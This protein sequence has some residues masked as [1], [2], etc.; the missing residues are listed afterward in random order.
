MF[1]AVVALSSI[2][3]AGSLDARLVG[4]GLFYS[5]TLA[6]MFTHCVRLSAEVENIVSEGSTVSTKMWGDLGQSV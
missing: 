4:L 2:P 3:L 1:L 6:I 5:L